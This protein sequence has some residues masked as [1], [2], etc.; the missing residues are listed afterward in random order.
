MCF[1]T[2][3]TVRR[4]KKC[5]IKI[6]KKKQYLH[7][8]KWQKINFCTINKFETSKSPIFG[9]TKSH[10]FWTY[11]LLFSLG[12][13][14][15]PPVSGGDNFYQNQGVPGNFQPPITRPPLTNGSQNP[16]YPAYPSNNNTGQQQPPPPPVSGGYPQ[17]P[18]VSGGDNF[19]Q[20]QGSSSVQNLASRLGN[21]SLNQVKGPN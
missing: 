18:P 16:K 6:A 20:N 8:Q 12:Q 13:P 10:N 5:N 3:N 21:F 11:I 15:P 1:C 14:P 19:Y 9:L 2:L 4:G 7:F 17:Q